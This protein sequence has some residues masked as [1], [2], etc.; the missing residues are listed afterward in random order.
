[1]DDSLRKKVRSLLTFKFDKLGT[2]NYSNRRKV[3]MIE[4]QIRKR[5]E[6]LL[7]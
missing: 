1:M 7:Q 3:A 6:L 2:Y 5:T 4:K